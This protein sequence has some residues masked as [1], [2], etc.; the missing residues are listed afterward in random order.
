MTK[1]LPS[2]FVIGLILVPS[3]LKA[4]DGAALM[5]TRAREAFD[6]GDYAQ[7]EGYLRGIVHDLDARNA[8]PGYGAMA[9]AD[10]GSALLAQTR[11]DEAETLFDRAISLLRS[12]VSSDS[13]YLPIVLGNLGR[14]HVF[15]G[16]WLKA[17]AVLKEALKSGTSM[18]GDESL[19]VAD[20][21]GT[22]GMVYLG[23]GDTKQAARELKAALRIVEEGG[24][25]DSSLVSALVN[26]A[27]LYY[28]QRDWRRAEAALSRSL[29][30]MEQ[31]LP[32][33][34]LDISRT[35]A[36]LAF[37]CHVQRKYDR[38]ESFLRRA[39]TLRREALGTREDADEAI[40]SALLANILASQGSDAEAE[41]LYERALSAQ[42]RTLG[43]RS[44][45]V[46]ATLEGFASLLR[47][48][49]RQPIATEMELR[50]AAIRRE[51][52][53]T[54]SA[55]GARIWQLR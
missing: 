52:N 44:A 39:I 10:L 32:S 17:E 26:A 51:L 27:T 46:A 7:A 33:R 53:F 16:R 49:N 31:S 34:R 29:T 45:E 47:R 6:R 38:A 35:L 22:L 1:F 30:I 9:I 8:T 25:D 23:T 50:A 24:P 54:T 14:L 2:I 3:V 13:R 5:H 36:R 20:W 43:P 28:V 40:L 12:D 37:V 41:V 11:I 18:M 21:R 48:E 42:E 55:R 19:Y 4:E 15:R